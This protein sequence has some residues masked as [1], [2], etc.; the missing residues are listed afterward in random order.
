MLISSLISRGHHLG[1]AR[2]ETARIVALNGCRFVSF[3]I[4]MNV[5]ATFE[6]KVRQVSSLLVFILTVNNFRDAMIFN[7]G[8][9]DLN[10]RARDPNQHL[11]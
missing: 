11:D 2:A 1:N 6:V 9:L 7:F 5:T 3:H 10:A 8:D 4:C